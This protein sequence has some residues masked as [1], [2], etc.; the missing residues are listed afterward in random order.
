MA[1]VRNQAGTL[2]GD[3]LIK[4]WLVFLGVTS[5]SYVDRPGLCG[6]GGTWDTDVSPGVG[7]PGVPLVSSLSLKCQTL[8]GP[9]CSK[10]L[11]STSAPPAPAPSTSLSHEP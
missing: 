8:Q 2:S 4:E 9:H 5:C 7:S 1:T 6:R 3:E 11:L 10:G